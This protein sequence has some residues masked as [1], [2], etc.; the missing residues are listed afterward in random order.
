MVEMC[1]GWLG[2]WVVGWS[3]IEMTP[4]DLSEIERMGCLFAKAEN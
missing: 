4:V 2:G 3:V 1:I